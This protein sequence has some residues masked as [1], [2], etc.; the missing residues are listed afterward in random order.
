MGGVRGRAARVSTHSI[1]RASVEKAWRFGGQPR[2]REEWLL[3]SAEG[4]RETRAV[5][6]DLVGVA[7]VALSVSLSYRF[8]GRVIA[9]VGETGATVFLRLC[10]F[11]LLCVGVSIM[12]GGVADL[13]RGLIS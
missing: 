4:D 5:L 10:S 8:A 9:L 13:V 2:R 7:I 3:R 6:S 12:W 1:R 11:I